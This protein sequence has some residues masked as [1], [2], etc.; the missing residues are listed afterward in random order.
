MRD[1][2][3]PRDFGA[4]CSKE[5]WQAELLTHT[6]MVL[7]SHSTKSFLPTSSDRLQLKLSFHLCH[8]TSLPRKGG[9]KR[10]CC[11]KSFLP[12]FPLPSAL[13]EE[14]SSSPHIPGALCTGKTGLLKSRELEAV[15]AV[16]PFHLDI[17]YDLKC[18]SSYFGDRN[19]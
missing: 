15:I 12:L 3:D 9:Q 5:Q 7:L 16:D 10:H 19:G 14:E 8:P 4:G 11:Q 2:L 18:F 1:T 13:S 6:H 17:F